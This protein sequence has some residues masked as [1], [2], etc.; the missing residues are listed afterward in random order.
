M[1]VDSGSA[2]LTR[3]QQLLI[4]EERIGGNDRGATDGQ[5][6]RKFALGRQAFTRHQIAA[7]DGHSDGV[8]ESGVE[9]TLAGRPLTEA[10]AQSAVCISMPMMPDMDM[11]SKSILLHSEKHGRPL[12][13]D[14]AACSR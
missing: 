4:S 2:A 6:P 5:G 12:W 1:R 8:G 9:R 3:L 7:V 13:P 14:D 10:L 11:D